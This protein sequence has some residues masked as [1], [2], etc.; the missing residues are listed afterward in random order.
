MMRE[1]GSLTALVLVRS[2]LASRIDE[3]GTTS[4]IHAIKF[5]AY[6]VPPPAPPGAPREGMPSICYSSSR[7]FF[8]FLFFLQVITI[9]TDQVMPHLWLCHPLTSLLAFAS[10]QRT[11]CRVLRSPCGVVFLVRRFP[12]KDPACPLSC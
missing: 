10:P 6:D 3:Y 4:E 2:F 12:I 11:G 7:G 8:L 9:Q 5:V 1:N